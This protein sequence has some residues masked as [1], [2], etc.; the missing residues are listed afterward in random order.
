MKPLATGLVVLISMLTPLALGS[1]RALLW[2]INAILVAIVLALVAGSLIT[3]GK[4]QAPVKLSPVAFPM[5]MLVIVV[6]WLGVQMMPFGTAFASH[7]AWQ[8]AGDALQLPVDGMITVNPLETQW[9]MIK[10]LTAGGFFLSVYC[11]ARDREYAGIMLHGFVAAVVVNTVYGLV[12]RVL[13]ID[14][15][16]WF[17]NVQ[18]GVLTGGFLNANSAAMHIGMGLICVL[19]LLAYRLQR[20]GR[21]SDYRSVRSH[22]HAYAGA[23]G[24]L[25]GLYIVVLLVLFICLFVTGSRGGIVFTIAG[26]FAGLFCF[27]A[28]ARRRV[29][30]NGGAFLLLSIG[31]IVAV[32]ALMELSG[33]RFIQRVDRDGFTDSSRIDVYMQ[34]LLA[35]RDHLLT[36]SGG[37]TFQDVYPMYRNDITRASV[38]DKAHNDYVEL[39]LGLGVPVALMALAGLFAVVAGCARG[40]FERRR[41][42]VYPIAAVSCAAYVALHS[43][44]DFGIQMQANA[45]AFALILGVGLA[46][47]SSGARGQ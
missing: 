26:L 11:L 19:T 1:N 28:R 10:W 41:D 39:F 37:G 43:F 27:W 14:K 7:P 21:E 23:F 13:S 45:L 5:L 6:I 33:A 17:E 38:W 9:S 40:I 31:L 34:S 47:S 4:R 18:A 12:M 8:L 24:G 44:F 42:Y 32:L 2:S 15:V 35:I 25:P 46:Q 16:L 20:I 30:M 3:E 29:G 22:I 36:G